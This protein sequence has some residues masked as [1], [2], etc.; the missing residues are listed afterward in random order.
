MV[1]PIC[2]TYDQLTGFCSNCYD[3][4]ALIGHLCQSQ[5]EQYCKIFQDGQ[6]I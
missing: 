3:G 6:C 2:K 4:Y 1:D 5:P